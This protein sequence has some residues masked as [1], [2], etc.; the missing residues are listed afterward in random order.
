MRDEM[1]AGWKWSWRHAMAG[2][3]SLLAKTRPNSPKTSPAPLDWIR[4]TAIRSARQS[5]L[6]EHRFAAC[7]TSFAHGTSSLC[8]QFP[9]SHPI[10]DAKCRH[11]P[12]SCF[13][14]IPNSFLIL[15]LCQEHR[16]GRVKMTSSIPH[17]AP[18]GSLQ[19]FIDKRRCIGQD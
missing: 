2:K 8:F 9:I 7:K 4:R 18:C 11:T 17:T 15:L 1:R 13:H 19:S 10:F 5:C 3:T 14:R 12:A 6:E 16:A